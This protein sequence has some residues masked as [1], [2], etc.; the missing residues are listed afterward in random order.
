MDRRGAPGREECQ[1]L[2][3]VRA[4]AVQCAGRMAPTACP[5]ARRTE[6]NATSW[7]KSTLEQL[8]TGVHFEQPGVGKVTISK[9]SQC[10]GEA[11]ANNRKAKLIFLFEWRIVLDWTG[12]AADGTSMSGTIDIANLSDENT[13]DEIDITVSVKSSGVAADR[14][15]DLAH[16]K[17]VAEVR[18]QLGVYMD[19]LRSEFARDLILPVD[20]QK[21]SNPSAPPAAAS[22]V[23]PGRR[24]NSQAS[25]APG[26]PREGG[27]KLGPPIEL[28]TEFL[29]SA[30]DVYG[31]L[32]DARRVS[33]WT[34]S[35]AKA[36]AKP[37]GE[38]ALFGG[39]VSGR[40]VELQPYRRIV[41]DW[42]SS[43]WPPGHYSRVTLQLAQQETSTTLKLTQTAVPLEDYERI[44]AGWEQNYWQ[45]IKRVFGY[46]AD[47]F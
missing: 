14:L 17:G 45:Q 36:D 4:G 35:E 47:V 42:R 11:T 19:R 8:L 25:S 27:V 41:Q 43:N 1:Q 12:Q 31:T 13:P 40:F 22:A 33:A 30:E 34:Q 29:A 20:R 28:H 26:V 21:S 2:A 38:F 46:G 7:S 9:M 6:K 32:V 10:E 18:K 5:V 23:D 44:H 16:T 39:Q 3:L 37:G 24:G 15:R